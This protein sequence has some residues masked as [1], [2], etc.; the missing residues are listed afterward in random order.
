MRVLGIIM[1]MILITLGVLAQQE[2]MKPDLVQR[3]IQT[4]EDRP[5]NT[6]ETFRTVLGG[7]QIPGGVVTVRGCDDVSPK[8]SWDLSHKPVGE[9]LN[10]LTAFD[11]RYRWEIRDDTINF[12]PTSGEPP[13][14]QTHIGSFTIKTDSSLD[15]LDQLEKLPE[16]KNAM[17][18]LRLTGGLTV[19]SYLSNFRQ[20]SLRFEGGTIRDALNAIAAGKGSDVWVYTETH[21]GDRHEVTLRF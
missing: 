2:K 20:F 8:K 9:L 7:A 3:E 10:A 1:T 12:L 13:L 5:M 15:A 18:N 16:F 14:L 17:K 6:A 4:S 21:C 19:V 11:P